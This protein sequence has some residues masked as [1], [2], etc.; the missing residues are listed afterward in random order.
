MCIAR[1]G[2]AVEVSEGKARVE[3]FDGRA[4]G[5]VDVSV[6]GAKEGEYVEVFGNLALSKLKPAE[7]RRRK[8]AWGE[9]MEG[10]RLSAGGRRAH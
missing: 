7:A 5:E 2:R 3:F 9:V 8:T 6:V 1:V 4:L 10:V